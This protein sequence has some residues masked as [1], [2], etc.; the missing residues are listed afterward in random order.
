MLPMNLYPKHKN[1]LEAYNACHDS[2]VKYCSALCYGKM[3]TEDLIQDVLLSAY[4]N[5][6]K[7]EKKD[8]LSHYL[9]RAA[10]NKSISNWR[11]KKPQVELEDS[12]INLT[13]KETSAESNHDIEYLYK[14][15]ACLPEAQKDAIVLYEI[16]GFKIKEIAKMQ[17]SSEGAIKTKI[18]RGR[19]KLKEMMKQ[20]RE[21]VDGISKASNQLEE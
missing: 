13:T 9:I 15:L 14:L 8:T 2:F 18:S 12:V 5:F 20:E 19:K 16:S 11:K 3:N 10:R 21:I 17:K 1:F 7:I 6:D 4:K